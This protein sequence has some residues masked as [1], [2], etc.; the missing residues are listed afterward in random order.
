MKNLLTL[1]YV[2]FGTGRHRPFDQVF[3]MSIQLDPVKNP[4]GVQ[5]VDAVVIWGGSD[6]SPSIYNEPVSMTCHATAKL[7]RND[8]AEVALI[9]A[10]IK[11]DKPIIGVC[12]GAQLAC[13]MA[14]G[15]LI[16]H[17]DGHHGDH[18]ITTHDGRSISTSSVHHQMM[19]PWDIEHKTIAWSST[20]RS[21]VHIMGDESN[22][23]VPYEPE[24][25]YF[26]SIRALAIQG[27]PEF[28]DDDC[29]FVKY[30][31]DLVRE[32]LVSGAVLETYFHGEKQHA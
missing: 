8:V 4:E 9:N 17:V 20:I 32:Y 3:P 23:T 16:Q 30:C 14:G 26:P 18:D 19:Y 2:P 6:I 21:K 12:R 10:A 22:I 24:I 31:N 28:M 1:G 13:A 15:K 29:E 7:A 27:H 11:H 25:V 5:D